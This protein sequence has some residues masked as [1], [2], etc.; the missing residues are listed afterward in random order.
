MTKDGKTFVGL[1]G[2]T[3]DRIRAHL[4]A[5]GIKGAGDIVA[6][7]AEPIAKQIDRVAHT[8]IIGCASC[9]NRRVKLNQQFPI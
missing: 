5:R 9:G 2:T 3:T 4:R 1:T 7:V 6:R 8:N